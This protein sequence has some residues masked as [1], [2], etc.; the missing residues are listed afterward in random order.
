[1]IV[2]DGKTAGTIANHTRPRFR[3]SPARTHC[4]SS[5]PS[6]QRALPGPSLRAT[7]KPSTS[8][9]TPGAPL[10]W[11]VPGPSHRCSLTTAGGS[12]AN[13]PDARHRQRAT[14]PL[15]SDP[16]LHATEPHA[17]QGARAIAERESSRCRPT[18]SPLADGGSEPAT[19]LTA[20]SS[21]SERS[22][23]SS[24]G[25]LPVLVRSEHATPGRS[26]AHL[27]EGAK[28]TAAPVRLVDCWVPAESTISQRWGAKLAA[29]G[30]W[31]R[32]ARQL[33]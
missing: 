31:D 7:T 12:Y 23:C 1:M 27:A 2:L 21:S 33:G 6:G 11:P 24:R 8:C 14:T 18:A 25:S 20:A 17:A 30:D 3:S 29:E 13:A 9:V 10:Y 28:A 19:S 4:N 32:A 16:R 5:S 15:I 26:A 22:P